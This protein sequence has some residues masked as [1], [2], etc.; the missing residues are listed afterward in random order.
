LDVELL[1]DLDA[2]S[3]ACAV[4]TKLCRAGLDIDQVDRAR[5][6]VSEL[7]SNA[8][9][10]GRGIITLRAKLDHDR[11]LVEVI[12]EGSGFERVV[13]EQN[14]EVPFADEV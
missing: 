6:L 11:L 2:S 3:R 9:L 12:D 10:H 1:R 8:V 5:L 13:R 14:Y 4:I 7:V